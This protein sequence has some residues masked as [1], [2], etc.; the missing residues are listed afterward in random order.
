MN[1]SDTEFISV[2]LKDI[3]LDEVPA[4]GIYSKTLMKTPHCTQ[5]L[6]QFGAHEELTEHT[7]KFA[8][9]LHFLKG[10]GTL[11]L[12]DEKQNIEEG[13]LVYM[14]PKLPHSV[15]TTEPTD[16]VLTLLKNSV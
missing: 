10:S 7:S 5:T 2:Q 13:L 9:T 16:M 3:K 4:G 1:G 8:A 15:H 6:M 14:P 11:I 12:G